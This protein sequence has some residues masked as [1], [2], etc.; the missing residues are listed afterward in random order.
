MAV[1]RSS[2]VL[3][4]LVESQRRRQRE[5]LARQRAWQSAVQ[6]Q[7]KAQRAAQRA[8]AQGHRA[9]LAAYQNAREAE[10]AG[11]TAD[12]ERM[13]AGLGRILADG[14]ALPPMQP[15]HLRTVAA[16]VPFRPGALGYP[17]PMPDP[18]RYQVP[19]LAAL[20]SISPA[21][22]R[23]HA[24]QVARA[25]LQYEHDWRTAQAAEAD[26]RR[27]LDE[28]HRR[29]QAWVQAQQRQAAERNAWADALPGR[30]AAGEAEG[31]REYVTAVMYLGSGWPEQFPREVA[32]DWDPAT[33]QA[34]VDWRLP[35]LDTIP[36]AT[37]IR[38]VRTTDEHKRIAMAPGQRAALYRDVLCQCT[39]RVVADLFRADHY[40]HLNS[41]VFNGYVTA[42]DPA[43]GQDAERC[44]ITAMISRADLDGV[45]LAEV[46]AAACLRQLRAQVSAR[47]ERQVPV[48]PGRRAHGSE[49]PAAAPAG[50]TD[51][52]LYEMEPDRFEDLVADLFRT[53][54]LD[55]VT[56]ARTGDGGVDVEACDPDPL[57]GGLI[58][59]QVKRYRATVAPSVVRDLYG[60][61][62]HRGATKGILVT[63]SG[64]GP[65]SH[66]FA[67]GKPLT[68]ISGPELVDLLSRHGLPGRL[69]DRP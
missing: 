68:L 34:I 37:R 42:R 16:V 65:G 66:E 20:Q 9:N 58:L 2:G 1:K 36:D 12:L 40:G 45:R 44:L 25:Q 59:I 11:E 14:L 41:V 19:P 43:T 24:E 13:I 33:R 62:Q 29:H 27:R 15:A 49:G 50:D 54:G 31:V 57:T 6:E 67:Q 61:V 52:D 64:F 56:T 8:A 55:V 46:D 69:G 51:P 23:G 38:Y 10:A 32:T 17:V 28:L 53:R 26:R 21:A 47:P 48:R 18:A 22:R 5:E 39:L 35:D 7:Q 30:L 4:L 60:V 63:T 3:T